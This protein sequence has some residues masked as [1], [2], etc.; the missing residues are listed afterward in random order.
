MQLPSANSPGTHPNDASYQRGRAW[1]P[2]MPRPRAPTRPPVPIPWL[3]VT[4]QVAA[5]FDLD[6]TILAASSTL[7]LGRTFR[8]LGLVGPGTAAR[9]AYAHAVYV[10]RGADHVQMERMKEFLTELVTGWD[11]AKVGEAVDDA[12]DGVLLPLVHP[13]AAELMRW[14]RDNDRDVVIVTSA[15]YEVVAPLLRRLGVEDRDIV[16]TRMAVADGRYTG[17]IDHYV[18][19]PAKAEAI[20]AMAEERGY[21]LEACWA[22]SD[23]F[24]DV[25]M[26]SAVGRPHAVNPDRRLAEH[27]RQHAWP[28][29][30]FTPPQA[31]VS[32]LVRLARPSST[33]AAGA[34]AGALGVVALTAGAGWLAAQRRRR[35]R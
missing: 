3:P 32:R 27:A 17:V 1:P 5:F 7:A 21:D 30:H 2:E 14:H 13:E 23:S 20:R 15:A 16:A 22:Y 28:V 6:K 4:G 35:D 34:A 29:L 8:D 26:L 12:V 33:T 19:G 31:A 10:L 11:V 24:T 9:S 18:Y 25:S